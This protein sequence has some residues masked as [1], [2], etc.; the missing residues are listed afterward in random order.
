MN[1]TMCV[2]TY[3]TIDNAV[4]TQTLA[5]PESDS[6]RQP[7]DILD[8]ISTYLETRKWPE[9]PFAKTPGVIFWGL[10][11]CHVRRKYAR[12]TQ[13]NFPFESSFVYYH[14]ILQKGVVADIAGECVRNPDFAGEILAEAAVKAQNKDDTS[15]T[16]SFIQPCYTDALTRAKR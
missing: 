16:S 14:W 6:A 15:D 9:E 5:L 1:N 3:T 10:N 13:L 11:P 7:G 4:R 12:S 8:N 2:V